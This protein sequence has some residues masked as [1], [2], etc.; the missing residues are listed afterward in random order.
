V[1]DLQR[2]D[3]KVM[4]NQKIGV[5]AGFQL[6]WPIVR[7]AGVFRGGTNWVDIFQG[8]EL[9]AWIDET[10]APKGSA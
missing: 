4:Y 3:A 2:H 8:S 10:Q 9:N 7:N 5:A 1:K 6:V